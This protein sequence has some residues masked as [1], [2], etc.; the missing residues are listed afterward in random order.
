MV[1]APA[2]AATDLPVPAVLDT[3][4]VEM[5]QTSDF[6]WPERLAVEHVHVGI[7]EIAAAALVLAIA[8]AVLL[9]TRFVVLAWRA[10]CIL[11]R[12]RRPVGPW[13]NDG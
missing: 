11:T 4:F 13:P 5:I 2:Q 6:H 12:R 1:D 7:A 3:A 9:L 10:I 8:A